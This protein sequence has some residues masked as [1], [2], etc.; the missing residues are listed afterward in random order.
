MTMKLPLR[1]NIVLLFFFLWPL[2]CADQ[3]ER[4]MLSDLCCAESQHALAESA[5][6]HESEAIAEQGMGKFSAMRAMTGDR[7]SVS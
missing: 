7:Q 5:R 2:P 1:E 3:K 4:S 6:T